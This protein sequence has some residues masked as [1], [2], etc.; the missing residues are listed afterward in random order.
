MRRARVAKPLLVLDDLK[1]R[2]SEFEEIAEIVGRLAETVRA[3]NEANKSAAGRNDEFARAYH[4]QID[5]PTGDLAD[6]VRTIQQEFH[7][8]GE[9]G[10]FAADNFDRAHDD[11]LAAAT[12]W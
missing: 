12:D 10:G 1:S 6:L 2:F 5:E 4:K 7:L 3:I 8:T 11:A 9:R